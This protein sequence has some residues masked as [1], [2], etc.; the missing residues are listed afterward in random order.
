MDAA[1]FCTL[2]AKSLAERIAWIRAEILPHARVPRRSRR[3]SPG[4]STPPRGSMR[5][6]T[7]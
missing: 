1:P 5:S 4:S 3:A 6:S 2:P 7:A